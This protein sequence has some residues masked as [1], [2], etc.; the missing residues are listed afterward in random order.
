MLEKV[1]SVL[2]TFYTKQNTSDIITFPIK[3][4]NKDY[5]LY[6]ID[7][8]K[9]LLQEM[10][11]QYLTDNID[12]NNLLTLDIA[13]QDYKDYIIKFGPQL[14]KNIKDNLIQSA[15]KIKSKYDND[16]A[17]KLVTTDELFI[18]TTLNTETLIEELK[19]YF[20]YNLRIYKIKC[21]AINNIQYELYAI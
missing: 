20:A 5:Y 17:Y 18:L 7:C 11:N 15:D 2:Y 12:N 10:L 21:F 19:K 1:L 4:K 16:F 3:F 9:C 14:N 13:E 8:I 6:I